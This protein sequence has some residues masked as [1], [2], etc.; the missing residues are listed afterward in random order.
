M[1][2]PDDASSVG[3]LWGGLMKPT[4]GRI[5]RCAVS[6]AVAV[7]LAGC[8]KHFKGALPLSDSA[9]ESIV[10]DLAVLG[11]LE[12]ETGQEPRVDEEG[13]KFL[14]DRAR[15]DDQSRQIE[16]DD[17]AL[18]LLGPTQLA[19]HADEVRDLRTQL[20]HRYALVGEEGEALILERSYWSPFIVLP[21][22]Y[23]VVW[24]TVPIETSAEPDVPH[25]MHVL[26]VVDLEE[27]EILSEWIEVTYDE[28]DDGDFEKDSIAD[29][30][31]GM[32]LR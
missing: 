16:A 20:G 19:L 1:Q 9:S 4:L 8:G 23:F 18:L 21:L 30:V 12:S 24:F 15:G 28:P 11:I 7:S 10:D 27:V 6:I 32:K 29:A 2:N 31:S 5:S 26:R 14:V 17:L 22:L 3:L 13:T 25:E